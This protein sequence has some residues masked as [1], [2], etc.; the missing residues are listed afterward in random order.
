MDKKIINIIAVNN[1]GKTNILQSIKAIFTNSAVDEPGKFINRNSK[2]D[3]SFIKFSDFGFDTEMQKSFESFVSERNNSKLT[4]LEIELRNIEQL[5][6]TTISNWPNKIEEIKA[7]EKNK[8][9]KEKEIA[10]LKSDASKF[11]EGFDEEYPSYYIKDSFFKNQDNEFI[12]ASDTKIVDNHNHEENLYE[13]NEWLKEYL[14]KERYDVIYES[15]FTSAILKDNLIFDKKKEEKIFNIFNSFDM[16]FLFEK[17]WIGEFDEYEIRDHLETASEKIT[18][19]F[20]SDWVGEDLKFN[21][22][23]LNIDEKRVSMEIIKNSS[24]KERTLPS[25]M[26]QGFTW[27]IALKTLLLNCDPG[28]RTIILLDEPSNFLHITAQQELVKFFEN[29]V[30]ENN[31]TWI[32]YTT[33]SPFMISNEANII[34]CDSENNEWKSSE[35]LRG[36][37]EKNENLRALTQSEAEH[38]RVKELFSSVDLVPNAQ[39]IFSLIKEK[40]YRAALTNVVTKIDDILKEILMKDK[41][42]KTEEEFAKSQRQ[43]NFKHIIDKNDKNINEDF[44]RGIS[45]LSL[46]VGKARNSSSDSHTITRELKEEEYLFHIYIGV[47]IITYLT[48]INK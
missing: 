6:E 21:I 39:K 20:L 31:N 2:N 26:S 1:K 23:I 5:H 12:H 14:L 48:S 19:Y 8:V 40:D 45:Q 37:N 36:K 10:S 29:F 34:S 33:H 17:P 15:D 9:D 7:I 16:G 43:K 22:S 41:V 35:E 47:G 13:I 27:K 4:S 28:K 42:Y 25:E 44:I 11:V 24:S 32:F 38:S 18:K 30:Q 3:E 46:L